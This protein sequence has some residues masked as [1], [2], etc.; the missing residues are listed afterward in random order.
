MNLAVVQQWFDKL[1]PRER[2]M[3]MAGA[4]LALVALIFAVGIRP[5][6]RARAAAAEQLVEQR[7][8]LADIEQVARR[9][10]PQSAAAGTPVSSESVVVLIDRSTRER[11]LSS[12]LKRNQPEGN[13][14]VRLRMENAPFDELLLWLSD[15]Q[16]GQ[17]L[18]AVSA[19][20]DPSG[21]PGR[22]NANLVLSP[23]GR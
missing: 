19:S 22:V 18:A 10:G 21:E 2:W 6:Y 3:V 17:G 4:L 16:S 7:R 1:A 9:F 14:G 8:L 11:G 5:V 13:D 15:V 23:T 12:Y 20:F